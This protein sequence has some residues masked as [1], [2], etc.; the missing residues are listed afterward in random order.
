[1]FA[2]VAPDTGTV[3]AD[4]DATDYGDAGSDSYVEVFTQSAGGTTT[5]VASNG[6]ASSTAS[7]STVS[8]PVTLGDTYYVAVTVY[9]N[10]SFSPT[11]PFDRVTN[12]TATQTEYDLFLSFDNGNAH[13]TAPDRRRR[14]RRHAR[15]R[16]HRLHDH[17][18]RGRRRVQVRRLVRLHAN[19]L[20]PARPDHDRHRRRLQ[21]Q[22]A[23]V[24]PEQHR[25]QHH[26]TGQHDRLRPEPDR[27]RHRRRAGLRIRDRGRQRQLQLVRPGQRQRRP[28]RLLLAH[29]RPRSTRPAPPPR[30]LNDNSID[31]GTPGHR[32]PPPP[33]SPATSA[34]DGGLVVGDADV[35]LYAF[36][37][38]HHRRVR[39]PHRHQ[40]GGQRRH[41]AAAVHRRRRAGGRQRQRRQPPPRPAS[42]APN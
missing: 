21:P 40:P 3:T 35:D 15:R 8:F 20:R 23:A 22:P 33:P 32:S 2:V 41:R 9:A 30:V 19:G 5:V 38:G 24:D 13:G 4:V 10:H 26:P 16:Q 28:D 42:S 14:V 25:R 39:R 12:S 1:M 11:D 27:H 31:G 7:D 34:M 29:V 37:P 17:R 6:V 18:A 36:T